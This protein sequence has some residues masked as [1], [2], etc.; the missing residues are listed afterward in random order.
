[1]RTT[2]LMLS[3]LACSIDA[4]VVDRDDDLTSVSSEVQIPTCPSGTW[5]QEAAPVSSLLYTAWAQSFNDVFA[6]GNGGV[7]LR[8]LNNEEWASMSSGTTVDLRGIWGT[9]S[10]DVWAVGNAGTVLHFDGTSW[11]T[12][13]T[14]VTTTNLNAVWQ[15]S[16]STIW[17][18]GGSKVWRSTD[19][20]ANWTSWTRSGVLLS[21]SGTD[22]NNVWATGENT[23][24]HKWNGTS[25]STVNP[26]AGTNYFSVLYLASNNVWVA[27]LSPASRRFTNKWNSV[28]APAGVYW[29]DLHAQSATDL[30]AAGGSKVGRW[31]SGSTWTVLT[32]TPVAQYFGIH[33]TT[34]HVWAVGSSGLIMHYAY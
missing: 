29:N 14:L 15:S 5:C 10:S 12:I 33:G 20:G 30:W 19:S 28:T 22:A 32:P 23:Q 7:I 1:M 16:S 11:S 4:D 26:G 9:S 8:R 6:V 27:P 2:L 17:I 24:A 13:T 31:S 21:I 25:W 34:G 3:L 18:V